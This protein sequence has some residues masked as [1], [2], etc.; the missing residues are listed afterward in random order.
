MQLAALL[1]LGGLLA[2]A[3]AFATHYVSDLTGRKAAL[4]TRLGETVDPEPQLR[5]RRAELEH[6]QNVQLAYQEL[7]SPIPM[8]AVI[9]QIQNDMTQGMALSNVSVEV[10]PEAVKGSGFV[11]DP[12]NPPKLHDV[13]RLAVVGISPNDAQIAQLIDKLTANPLFT[14]VS[15]NY[16]RTENVR[17][18]AVRRFE[19]RM[20]MDVE[21]LGTEE[22]PAAPAP[23][24][25]AEG[26]RL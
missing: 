4:N 18:Y 14:G 3:N 15:L 16:T 9:Q 2:G 13:A 23:K 21:Q 20:E 8:S 26:S 19:I 25:V 7:G 22:T 11:G 17:E 5:T 10:Q 6:L 12:K 24:A 1:V